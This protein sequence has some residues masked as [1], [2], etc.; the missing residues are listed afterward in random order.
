VGFEHF[1]YFDNRYINN[2]PPIYSVRTEQKIFLSLFLEDSQ[3]KNDFK[4]AL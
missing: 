1:I 2:L 4:E 3:R